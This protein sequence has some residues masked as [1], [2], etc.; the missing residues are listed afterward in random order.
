MEAL[1]TRN[2][3]AMSQGLK[4]ARAAIMRLEDEGRKKEY[5]EV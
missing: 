4:D 2:F 3:E 5:P 1:V